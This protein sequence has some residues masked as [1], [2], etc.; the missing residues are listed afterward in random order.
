MGISPE[1]LSTSVGTPI[2]ALIGADILNQ[3]DILIDPTTHALNLSEDELPLAGRS[4]ELDNFMGI[5][6][7]EATVGHDVVRMF[8]D[9]GAKLSYLDSDRTNAFQ[10]V[11]TERDFYPGL[12]EFSTNAYDIPIILAT[13]TIVLRVGNLPQLLQMTLMMADTAGILGTAILRT[14]KV[15]FAPRRKTMTS[16]DEWMIACVYL[17]LA[18]LVLTKLGD[19]ASTLHRIEHA[20]RETNPFARHIRIWLCSA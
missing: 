3:Y 10:S 4:L 12:G 5:P 13:E 17:V 11:G 19:V 20:H 1:S 7:I 16:K 18:L 9:T 8:F 15:T 2:N 14:H 6:I